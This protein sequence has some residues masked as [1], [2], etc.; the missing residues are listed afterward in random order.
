M[1]MIRNYLKIAFRNLLRQKE[2][3]FINL[4]GLS[5]GLTCCLLI[6]V[7]VRYQTSYDQFHQRAGQIY[8]VVEDIVRPDETVAN[9]S[10]AGPV[11]GSGSGYSLNSRR[12]R[13]PTYC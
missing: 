7:Y 2:F 9:T 8:R 6:A 4:F 1:I 11:A 12:L 10:V 5:F 13:H 3:S